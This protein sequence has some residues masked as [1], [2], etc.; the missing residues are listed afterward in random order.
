MWVRPFREPGKLSPPEAQSLSSSCVHLAPGERVGEH[1]TE[2]KEELLFVLDGE[3][4]ILVG[5]SATN[6]PAG[7]VAYV[8]PNT[9][10]DVVNGGLS[11]LRYV[12]V[13]GRVHASSGAA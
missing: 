1:R 4:T 6:V 8:P 10:H 9:R 5:G 3:A 11:S 2:G 12:Y 13:T 7:T